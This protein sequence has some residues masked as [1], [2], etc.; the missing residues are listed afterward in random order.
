MTSE[1]VKGW[2][3]AKLFMLCSHLKLHSEPIWPMIFILLSGSNHGQPSSDQP[4]VADPWG[5][6]SLQ[7]PAG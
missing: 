3:A 4:G 6:I 7:H 2:K 5:N 1:P